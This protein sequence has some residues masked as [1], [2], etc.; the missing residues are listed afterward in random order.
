MSAFSIVI[1][2]I[3][4]LEIDVV[5]ILRRNASE[6]GDVKRVIFTLIS[7][8]LH[9]LTYVIVIDRNIRFEEI[10]F[11]ICR[12]LFIVFVIATLLLYI[13][14]PLVKHVIDLCQK[15]GFAIHERVALQ[16]L[17]F[18]TKANNLI[19]QTFIR[20]HSEFDATI[21]MKPSVFS[22]HYR[23]YTT[24]TQTHTT[25]TAETNETF[26]TC[27]FFKQKSQYFIE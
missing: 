27:T 17:R 5:D 24:Q 22:T 2:I 1:I 14:N 10:K 25:T 7:H 15:Y 12:N 13:L 8:V 21:A 20:V 4:E 3:L 9:S 11:S 26:R 23:L 19:K 6:W 16:H 18:D